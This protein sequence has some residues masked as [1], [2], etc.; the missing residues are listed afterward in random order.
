MA[1]LG[2]RPFSD[3][4]NSDISGVENTSVIYPQQITSDE[5]MWDYKGLRKNSLGKCT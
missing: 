5:D 1:V 3:T 4:H 2:V